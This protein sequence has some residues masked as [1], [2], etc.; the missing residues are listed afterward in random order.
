[1]YNKG[2]TSPNQEMEHQYHIIVI[3]YVDKM[4]LLKSIAYHIVIV[5]ISFEIIIVVPC[6][7]N[8]IGNFK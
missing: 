7:R 2:Q 4:S 8:Q 3:V 1:M 6:K 5:Y